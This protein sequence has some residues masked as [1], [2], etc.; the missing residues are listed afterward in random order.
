[1]DKIFYFL[2][3]IVAVAFLFYIWKGNSP[4]AQNTPQKPQRNDDVIRLK[5]SAYERLSLLLERSKP[6]ALLL[7]LMPNVE[8]AQQ[9]QILL[10]NTIIQEFEHNYSQQI[11]V[12]EDLWQEISAT[13]EKLFQLIDKVFSQKS[14]KSVQIVAEELLEEYA[15]EHNFVEKTLQLLRKEARN[16][17][18]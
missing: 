15:K 13:K 17:S 16:L 9:L 11:Y 12:S 8:N 18:K 3:L 2:L 14:E 5:I 7:R 1:M 6:T 10:L 4:K